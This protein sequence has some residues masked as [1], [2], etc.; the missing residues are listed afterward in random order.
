MRMQS[1]H[2]KFEHGQTLVIMVFAMIFLLFLAALVIDGGHVFVQHRIVQN[3]ADNSALAGV[4]VLLH[5][6]DEPTEA[7]LLA[8]IRF[9]AGANDV[10]DP[11]SNVEA[12]YTNHD[13]IDLG[14][15][16]VVGTCGSIPN[17]A[18]G[19]RVITRK[20]VDTFFASMFG[21][22]IFNANAQAI[23]VLRPGGYLSQVDSVL[24]ALGGGCD[25]KTID[26]SGSTNYIIGGI[27][28]N[29]DLY[30][31][32]SN[33]T[34]YGSVTT[35]DDVELSGSGN[36][37]KDGYEEG[38][39]SISDPFAGLSTDMFKPSG[40]EVLGKIVHDIRPYGSG[41]KVELEK[42]PST[43]YNKST[44]KLADGVYYAGNLDIYLG[45][46]GMGG[47][48]TLVTDG[49]IQISDRVELNAYVDGLLL[50]SGKN[51]LKDYDPC[52]NAVIKISGSGN[53][54]PKVTES[55]GIV[56]WVETDSY[57]RGLIY[58]PHGQVEFSGSKVS[59][60]GAVV[61]ATIKENGSDLLFVK[62]DMATT[63]QIELID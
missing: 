53:N 54:K 42:L 39:S 46:G 38:S 55:G 41:D 23:A 29:E 18:R 4:Y 25:E 34:I 7:K 26:G 35:V 30:L 40:S 51:D 15:C 63:M 5:H 44:R 2:N 58:A 20:S 9:V 48:V 13:G 19:V 1:K 36:V 62:D 31:G 60:I 28:S 24:V 52:K 10:V 56:Y 21:T 61:S 6:E 45:E 16:I 50:Y 57:L 59:V 17:S 33:Y 27:H 12:F 3:A 8:E 11:A 49:I 22:D 47:T 14:G 32:G 37:F 43:L